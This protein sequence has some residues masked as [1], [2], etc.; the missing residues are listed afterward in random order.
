[1]AIMIADISA[2]CATVADLSII[3][4]R[5]TAV[6]TIIFQL[7]KLNLKPKND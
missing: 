4:F 5:N 3:H 1:M 2:A 6:T 7:R